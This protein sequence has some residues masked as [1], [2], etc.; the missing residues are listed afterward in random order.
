MPALTN[1]V[2]RSV[3]Q[4]RAALRERRR[5][6]R[7]LA[8][9]KGAVGFQDKVRYK[10]L[11]DRRPLLTTFADKVA[12]RDYVAARV[13][14]D[15]LPEIYLVTSSPDDLRR[16]ELPREFALKPSHASGACVVVAD[17]A[18]EGA[19]LPEMPE[20]FAGFLVRPE[21]AD[22]VR[23]AALGDHWLGR[24][25]RLHDEWCYRNVP[26]RILVEELLSA[27][28]R[29][30]FDV[31]LSVIHGR[32]RLIQVEIDRY[33]NHCRNFYTP[34]WERLDVS[35]AKYSAGDDVARPAML[36]DM[37]RIAEVLGEE[38]DFVRVD[39]YEVGSRIVFGEL[40]NYPE[41]GYAQFVPPDFDLELGR[42][43]TP[44]E[45]YS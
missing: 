5:V 31:K 23:L 33:T 6:R 15:V 36:D 39:L 4:A 2:A 12:V 17:F 3:R 16:A 42:W 43:W 44:P 21:R 29:V 35:V 41:A 45:K 9:L 32:V 37:V 20:G 14:A 24:G 22:C 10:M 1:R 25:Y 34:E 7:E 18:P 27:G 40:T 8:E 13:G 11:A 38:T 30:P 19:E 28:D 26:R